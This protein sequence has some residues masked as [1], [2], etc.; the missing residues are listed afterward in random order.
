MPFGA[1]GADQLILMEVEFNASTLRLSGTLGTEREVE[2]IS[3]C[4]LSPQIYIP[5]EFTYIS[6]YI[7]KPTMYRDYTCIGLTIFI[8][9]NCDH[10][11]AVSNAC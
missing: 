1:E 7:I 3:E 11:T 8:C 10:V 5:I 2:Q 6:I 4:V 9:E